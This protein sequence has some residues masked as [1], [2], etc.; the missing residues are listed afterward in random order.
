MNFDITRFKFWLNSTTK[1]LLFVALASQA[2]SLLADESG[3]ARHIFQ[4]QCAA[5][6]LGALPEAPKV[7]AL[8]MYPPERIVEALESGVMS[9]QGMTLSRTEKQQLA[10][11]ITGKKVDSNVANTMS[12]SCKSINASQP[13][14]VA[15][16]VWNGWG[17]TT[18]NLRF[19]SQESAIS[20][21]NVNELK[22]SW[23]FAFPDATRVRSQ[24]L[25]TD[26]MVYIGSQEGMIYAL[27]IKSG[28][29]HWQFQAASEVRGAL[30]L[31]DNKLLFG[32]FKA[33]AYALN[34][35]SGQKI[36]QTQVHDHP[37][38][39][40]TGSVIADHQKLYVPVSSTEIIPAAR[41]DYPCCSFRG[42]AVAI[43]LETGNKVWT[44]YTTEVPKPTGKSSAGTE[45]FGPSGAPIWSGPTL[46]LKRN[47]LYVTTGQNYSSPATGTSDAVIAMDLDSG[48][49]KWVTQV[50][51]DDAWN[52]ACFRKTPNCPKE[53]GPDF[54][55]GASAMLTHPESGKQL[56]IIGQ[57]SGM[58]Y[59]L[60]PEENGK[61]VWQKRVG[62]GG[63]MG[64]VHW[65][66]SS[67]NRSVFVG[68]SDLE[69]HNPYTVG[70]PFPGL[71]SLSLQTGEFEWRTELPN[72]C[73]ET[74]KFLCFNGISAAVSSSPGLVFAGS[75]D[76][77]FRIFSA[78]NG[79]IVWEFDTK[80]PIETVN[81]VAG[82]GGAIE[83]DGPV[84]ANGRVFVTSGYDKW[85]EAPGNLLL[86]FST[87]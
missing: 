82:F 22:L 87:Q 28:C 51:K 13:S 64:G 81:G 42:A 12:Y 46:D 39:T 48:K 23:A 1:K 40:I 2:G 10:E 5:C 15:N 9:V 75:L 62:K 54:D 19:Q 74:S 65:G 33:N 79:K 25:I 43:D 72:V 76:G 32:D 45:Q 30:F 61:I 60:D 52:G 21:E 57:K 55:I 26:D 56:L 35:Q 6:H 44:R 84:V 86:M 24:P 34:A 73:P 69:T 58:V 38:A 85:G 18:N 31:Q 27:D 3:Q 80:K 4:S 83:S 36:W 7:D 20:L 37:L 66:M 68:V 67:D 29:V 11:F 53:N 8:K 78:K 49:V 70:D 17:G 63:T 41:A 50:T 47:L 14:Q 77:M 59:A 16:S 71:H